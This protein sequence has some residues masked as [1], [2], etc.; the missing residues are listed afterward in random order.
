MQ[1]L[2]QRYNNYCYYISAPP[3]HTNKVDSICSYSARTSEVQSRITSVAPFKPTKKS[4]VTETMCQV[5]LQELGWRTSRVC[6][7]RVSG[8]TAEL[9]QSD[10][11]SVEVSEGVDE[12]H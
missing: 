10:R 2:K 7:T 9:R 1:L 8:V 11:S 5:F 4:S 3:C 12:S 6:V